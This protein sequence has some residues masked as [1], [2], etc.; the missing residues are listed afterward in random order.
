MTTFNNSKSQ[1]KLKATDF[2]FA[3]H[4][5]NGLHLIMTKSYKY[6]R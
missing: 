6:Y 2:M 3:H 1:K 4:L 5:V